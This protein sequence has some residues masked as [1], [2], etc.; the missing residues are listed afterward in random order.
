MAAFQYN[1]FLAFPPIKRGKLKKQRAVFLMH[2]WPVQQV[3]Y[4]PTDQGMGEAA[5]GS[6][7]C[8]ALREPRGH[9]RT[10][11]CLTDV[12]GTWA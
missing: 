12:P 1:A 7:S 5:D 2:R 8:S 10:L 11:P 4:Q 6:T 3:G 9:D